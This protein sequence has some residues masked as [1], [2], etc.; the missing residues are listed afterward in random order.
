VV[1]NDD[2]D[3]NDKLVVQEEAEEKT[4]PSEKFEQSEPILNEEE[5]IASKESNQDQ[6][7]R[8]SERLEENTPT[9]ING[10]NE[11][12]KESLVE[13]ESPPNDTNEVPD[14]E[15]SQIE[16]PDSEGNKPSIE[17]TE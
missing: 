8:T 15:S 16:E 13:L 4:D 14:K 12:E 2:E 9:R 17:N 10:E 7:H 3:S 1:I 5:N 11:T 6:D